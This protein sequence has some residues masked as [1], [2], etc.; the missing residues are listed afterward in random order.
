MVS[1]AEQQVKLTNADKVLYPAT[2]T[3]KSDVFD[4]YT[5]IAEVMVPHIAGRPATRKRWPN[6]VEEP[7]F[8]EKQLASSA[9]DWLPRASV[10][11]RSGTTTY[12]IIDSPTA[13][14]WIGQQAALEVHVPQWRFIGEPGELKPGPATRLVFDLD[15]GDGVTMAQLAEVARAVRDLIADIGLTTFP[16]TS[17][18]KGLHLYTPL[19]EPVSSR[20]ATV[21][22]KR[23]AQQ[24]ENAMPALVTS[25]MTKSLRAGKVFLDWSQNSGSKTTI[26]PYSLRGREHPTVAAPRSWEE[27]DDPALGQLRYD[28]VLARV[29]HDG[30]LLA[31]LDALDSRASS[32]DRLT[33]YRSM[34]DASKTPEP[35]PKLKP[36]TGQGN[37]FVIQ[38]HHA[39]RLHYDFRLERD[40]V[41]VS[42]AVPKNL[43]DTTSVNH[44]AV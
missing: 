44:L 17:G 19:D 30:D 39:R 6:G 22:A 23:V 3:T 14:A 27:L 33:K 7:S 2:S 18:S 20:G 28:E 11:H 38:E 25:T 32:T 1:T 35:V 8:F 29:A 36:A 24:L 34:R 16:L 26:A 5:R 4:Y 43:P 15:P 31:L 42:W 21:L 37:T 41:L 9:P 40:G 13:L 12:P 10:V